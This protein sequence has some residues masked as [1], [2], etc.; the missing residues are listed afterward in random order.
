M[1]LDTAVPFGQQHA[2]NDDYR[3]AM[4][5]IQTH[6]VD[7]GTATTWANHL[8]FLTADVESQLRS[9]DE[10]ISAFIGLQDSN[11]HESFRLSSAESSESESVCAC[12]N[13]ATAYFQKD[14]LRLRL[15]GPS[16]LPHCVHYV[17]VSYCWQSANRISDLDATHTYNINT[18]SG[19]RPSK[20]SSEILNRTIAFAR[21]RKL[22]YIWIDQECIDQ[23]D[24][25]DQREG[26]QAMD[27][28][29]QQA[30][31]C[32][33]L[34]DI[35]ISEQEHVDALNKMF[36]GEGISDHQLPALADVLELI[37]S[38][39][40]FTRAWI[41]Q[42]SLT[43]AT[44]M[45]LQVKCD[46]RLEKG[47]FFEPMFSISSQY[48]EIELTQFHT[49]LSTW[50]PT[51]VED[52][53][54]ESTIGPAI[55]G[56]LT[57]VIEKWFAAL[58]PQVPLDYKPSRRLT[59]NA[60][61]AV[62]YL[63]RRENT[64]IADRI[65]I[66]ANLC[67][68]HKRLDSIKLDELGFNFSLCALVLSIMNGDISILQGCVHPLSNLN[69]RTDD[70][71][72]Q[73]YKEGDKPIGFTWSLPAWATLHS[74]R[75]RET[76]LTD[77][78]LQLH[79]SILTESGWLL[80]GWLWHFD[81]SID[82]TPVRTRLAGRWDVSDLARLS[83]PTP[84]TRPFLVDMATTMLCFLMERGY[85]EMT[86]L[87]WDLMRLRPTKQQLLNLP[88]TGRYSEASFDQIIDVKMGTVI[89]PSPIPPSDHRTYRPD[90][91]PFQNLWESQRRDVRR[92]FRAIL[93]DGF[94]PVGRLKNIKVSPEA[95]QAFFD[96]ASLGELY[97]AP[98]E[99]YEGR[100]EGRR[101]G[102]WQPHA[103]QIS[104]TCKRSPEGYE[105]FACHR[106]DIGEWLRDPSRIELAC[107]E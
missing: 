68:Y 17:A 48:L 83:A 69:G 70:L 11:G 98:I 74:L 41:L 66:M 85:T 54:A 26:I 2:D 40:W 35:Y 57:Q 25:R 19:I 31:Y 38:D 106:L 67:G 63:N 18:P 105:I 20:A 4:L 107:L 29:Y 93:L 60:A 9:N 84:A 39:P 6:Q 50:L 76:E 14:S 100:I 79:P 97:F 44:Q 103:F 49:Y 34:L 45:T 104:Q 80:D 78:V 101:F 58:P 91:D 22:T 5:A 16:E 62:S 102:R 86:N 53:A 33:G 15:T 96:G 95:Y 37:L 43:G 55:A 81:H 72:P 59:C 71:E 36:E 92:I 27:L 94:L 10:S 32:L 42:E 88:E 64:V 13:H 82:L 23:N 89:W 56:R 77:P 73:S 52:M 12:E 30:E 8:R 1:L 65:A 24:E 51:T 90:R 28:V 46:P 75:Y 99:H 61:A 7:R 21:P 3:R 47:V 87:F